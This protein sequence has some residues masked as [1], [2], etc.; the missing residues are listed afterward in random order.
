MSENL[1]SKQE[2]IVQLLELLQTSEHSKQRM[3]EKQKQIQSDQENL[4][5]SLRNQLLTSKSNSN[6]KTQQ[7]QQ[8][9]PT[10][11]EQALKSVLKQLELYKKMIASYEEDLEELTNEERKH[12]E[13][14]QSYKQHSE[15]REKRLNQQLNNFEKLIESMQSQINEANDLHNISHSFSQSLLNQV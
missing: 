10:K 11:T 5:E 1:V 2:K 15:N 7:Q 4:I 8:Q 3:R 9:S 14:F 6:Q 12:E 13:A